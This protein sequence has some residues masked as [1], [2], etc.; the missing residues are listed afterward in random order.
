VIE[1]VQKRAPS[2]AAPLNADEI[3][4]EVVRSVLIRCIDR[5]WQEHLLNIDHLRTEVH[6]RV[7]GQKDPLLEFKHEAFILFDSFSAKL[8]TEIAHALFK[9]KMMVPDETPPA[10][11][12]PQELEEAEVEFRTNLSLMPEL[13]FTQEG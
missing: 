1:N 4:R 6:L 2:Q 9:F 3:L 7:V 8:K 11:E 12:K 5:L 13:E 10:G